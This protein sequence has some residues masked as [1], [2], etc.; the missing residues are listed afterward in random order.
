MGISSTCVK[1][2]PFKY[3]A[4]CM[5]EFAVAQKITI[6]APP[7]PD[8]QLRRSPSAIETVAPRRASAIHCA[9]AA[10]RSPSDHTREAVAGGASQKKPSGSAF[11]MTQSV[12]V[13]RDAIL[14][15]L[16][17]LR[18]RNDPLPNARPILADGERVAR[19]PTVP[20]A[21]HRDGR[22]IRR[23]YA[24]MG[25]GSAV[26]HVR[27]RGRRTDGSEFPLETGKCPAQSTR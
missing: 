11:S 3:S 21:D 9:V 2:N 6:L 17:R 19:T 27:I 26:E 5:R 18:R 16:S 15:G 20:V 22:G 14:V 1:P 10:I 25:A 7:R 12:D 13:R 23:P 8:V 4:S 24:E